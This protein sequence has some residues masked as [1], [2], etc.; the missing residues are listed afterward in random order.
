MASFFETGSW[1]WLRQNAKDASAP[2]E[3]ARVVANSP[4]ETTFQLELSQTQ[5]KLANAQLTRDIVTPMHSTSVESVED[6]STLSDLHEGAILHNIRQRYAN[7]NVYTFIGSILAAVNPYKALP[8][9]GDEVLQKYNRSVLGDLPPHIYAIA[10]EAFY[11]M[12]ND[13]RNQC[14]LISGESGAGKT[15]STKFI[16]KFLSALSSKDS[17]VEQQILQSSAILEAFGNAKTVYNNNS[18]RFGK[19]ISVQFSEN[20]SIEGAKLTDYLLEKSR[21]VRQNPQ[22]RNYHI[23]YQLFAGLDASEKELFKLTGAPDKFHYMNQSGCITDP[24]IDDKTDFER[25]RS[26][27]QVMAFTKEQTQDLLKALA[28]IL[29][30]GNLKFAQEE[31][32]PVKIANAADAAL[33][34]E[35]FGIEN[36]LFHESMCSKKITMRGESISTPL[37]LPAAQDSRD[38]LSMNIYVRLFEWII[39]RINRII[40]AK[41]TLA[42]IGVL[43][44][45]GF[46]NFKV[47]SFEQ[48]CINYANEKLQM[49]FNQHIFSL[50]QAE[51]AK[52]N[53]NWSSIK[54]VD[55]QACIDM[56]ERH[57]GLLDL[58]DEEARFPKGTDETMLG[59]FN[60][61][62]GTGAFYLKPRMAAKAFGIK[63]YAGD[64]QYEVAGFLD[65]NRDT[66]REDLVAMLQ[67]SSSDFIYDLFEKVAVSDKGAKGG[68]K[69]PT[70][71]S[72]FK[73]SLGALMQALGAAHPFFV[74]C[75]KPNMQKVKDSFDATVVMNQLRYSGMLETVRI[76]RT[77]FPV[78]RAFADFLYRYKV[79][80]VTLG[81]A[82]ADPKGDAKA[83]CQLVLASVDKANENWQ[84]GTTKVFLR[85]ALE[86][87]LEKQRQE[88][89]KA[90]A[91]KIKARIMG[92]LQ[93]KR[94]IKIRRQVVIV[95]KLVRRY[96]ARRR[97]RKAVKSAILIQSIFRGFRARRLRARLMEA[98]RK[99]EERRREEERR[100][101]EERRKEME[102][103][104]RENKLRELEEMR[105]KA[106][107]EAKR[108]AEEEARK[109]EAEAKRQAEDAAKAR[110]LTER[111]DNEERERKRLEAERLEAIAAEERRKQEE[112]RFLS[113]RDA[114]LDELNDLGNE[115]DDADVQ[116]LSIG[117]TAGGSTGGGDAS[118]LGGDDDDDNDNA[119]GGGD[120]EDEGGESADIEYEAL[121]LLR[122]GYILRHDTGKSAGKKAWKRKWAV[123][124]EGY[125]V[126]FG[127][128][129]NALK[130]G[131]VIKQSGT[132]KNWTRH[133]L[134][135]TNGTL[136]YYK[137][138][139]EGEEAINVLALNKC[140]GVFEA[141]GSI[142]KDNAF[143]I[144]M[145]K[146][147]YYFCTDTIEERALWVDIVRKVHTGMTDRSQ[148]R[149]L[150]TE[151]LDYKN[152]QEIIETRYVVSIAPTMPLDE[153]KNVFVLQTHTHA[154]TLAIEKH[155][156]MIEWNLLL[157]PKVSK[158]EQ[159][160]AGSV[161]EGYLMKKTRTVNRRRYVVLKEDSIRYYKKQDDQFAV[162]SIELNSLCTVVP[163]VDIVGQMTHQW[164]F[165]VNSRRRTLV[166]T[167]K[168]S[169]DAY[170]WI[171]AI[172]EII[173]SKPVIES[174]T[175]KLITEI[176]AVKASH[177]GAIY[178]AYPILTYTPLHISAS[179]LALPYGCLHH[180]TRTLHTEALSIF[181][182]LLEM[183]KAQ[184]WIPH[185]Q[186]V[187]QFAISIAV[188][189]S[190]I[191]MQ[192]VK[193]TIN[194][195]KPGSQ[196]HMRYW[197]LLAAL[198][199]VTTPERKYQRYLRFYLKRVIDQTSTT[200]TVMAP[201]LVLARSCLRALDERKKREFPSSRLELEAIQ[202]GT[203]VSLPIYCLG[204]RSC[205]VS[206][207][208]ATT[209]KD[210]L[211]DIAKA[212]GL[213]NARNRFALFEETED[214]ENSHFV[215]ESMLV[216]DILAKWDMLTAEQRQQQQLQYLAVEQQEQLRQQAVQL[217]H[218]KEKLTPAQQQQ[219]QQQELAKKQKEE[220]AAAA[221]AAAA[222]PPS[223]AS[224]YETALRKSSMS[225]DS[226]SA[227]PPP[228]VTIIVDKWRLVYRV[229][230]FMETD[231]KR[232]DNPIEQDCLFE[233]THVDLVQFRVPMSDE[234][235][236]KLAALRLQAKLGDCDVSKDIPDIRPFYPI[237]LTQ[238]AKQS[239]KAGTAGIGSPA[240]SS[241]M[242]TFRKT[243]GTLRRGKKDDPM[244]ASESPAPVLPG[245]ASS[246]PMKIKRG[247]SASSLHGV[248]VGEDSEASHMSS[249]PGADEKKA[250]KFGTLMKGVKSLAKTTSSSA[251]VS[252]STSAAGPRRDD[253]LRV[254]PFDLIDVKAVTAAIDEAWINLAGT[255]KPE[256]M[257]QYMAIVAFEWPYYGSAIFECENVAI[258]SWPKDIL[259][260]VN[261]KGITVCKQPAGAGALSPADRL[262]TYPY[263]GIL[264]YSAPNVNSLKFVVDSPGKISLTTPK[265]VLIT[266]IIKSY[267]EE[268]V[269][270]KQ[271]AK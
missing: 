232:I 188:L 17:V 205:K 9:Y 145:P 135:L 251:L 257:R 34:A 70:V 210:I 231:F 42:Y 64:V 173:D 80:C 117:S 67:E 252:S 138:S 258:E 61:Q 156:D 217:Q 16:L 113:E 168:S 134:V 105:R 180:D 46:E 182:T 79:L 59:K 96:L 170:A 58:L 207:S 161:M 268:L 137:S 127:Q 89:L 49:Y 141:T 260:I 53:I 224:L 4:A 47:N 19:Y 165:K 123:L 25:V 262:G 228:G 201:V 95:Q 208:T 154:Y 133:Y 212:L 99:E 242:G 33:A 35:F 62:H 209:V 239:E 115:L 267:I 167:S 37:E 31:G 6:M 74:R 236:I 265:A 106:E 162:D 109:K 118:G 226:S 155:E 92:Y 219:L 111:L 178:A 12:L 200:S 60:E 171:D 85:E 223:A 30:L 82:A 147:T 54:W 77:G 259:L 177:V 114:V 230:C 174:K 238:T 103:L 15:E 128:K 157:L 69:K 68:R 249:S 48:F 203:D 183:E 220:A 55:N 179:L 88:T 104:E 248:D 94:F 215:G 153:Q 83:R 192:A 120:D 185:A 266:T 160:M 84:L 121:K 22:E 244:F 126:L 214:H 86:A 136:A 243:L 65:K 218:Q 196:Q 234:Q 51:Y 29:H 36:Q 213:S 11:A 107:E 116:S 152:A 140:S 176:K 197:Y 206:V 101:A 143:G 122:E 52:E 39:N 225:N 45:F 271:G 227:P 125:L 10:N 129:P 202:Q 198:C 150:E 253:D 5:V 110:A 229:H 8:I 81:G 13:K 72:Q 144:I 108:A 191:F 93:R 102:R 44:I 73:D 32:Q 28:G 254:D 245:S 41:D 1:V 71:S 3:A 57:L 100:K 204:E 98:K 237:F 241:K 87:V 199:N 246:S 187:L 24:S 255:S 235:R 216:L 166:F 151:K 112:A 159:K 233:Q 269:K 146:K 175:Q 139:D 50:E 2:L 20:G 172:R 264:S 90:V 247:Q 194:H 256:A 169:E 190:E 97:F 195:P 163:P 261:Q 222:A 91:N 149:K 38:S 270:Q 131:W 263:F 124:R 63:H 158:I 56:I 76:R 26:A 43:D 130:S 18:S 193:Q 40:R 23:F 142:N 7:S 184:D 250:G 240:G 164:T 66:F 186:N 27:M 75:I 148:L 211:G 78:R 119:G 21:V 189:R 132:L 181:R 14:V 221:A